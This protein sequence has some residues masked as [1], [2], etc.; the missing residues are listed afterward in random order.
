MKRVILIATMLALGACTTVAPPM[1]TRYGLDPAG[2]ITSYQYQAPVDDSNTVK[3]LQTVAIVGL[4]VLG[5]YFV[6]DAAG[7]WDKDDPAPAAATPANPLIQTGGTATW[8]GD[9]VQPIYTPL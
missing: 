5:M 9:F 1:Q 6:M 7:V 4:G 2:N 8:S 3:V